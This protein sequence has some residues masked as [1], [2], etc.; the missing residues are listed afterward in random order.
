[1][2]VKIIFFFRNL[3]QEQLQVI[4]AAEKGH[5]VF[6]TGQA[7]TGKSYVVRELYRRLERQGKKV[8]IVCSSGIACLVYAA[9]N[10]QSE[11]TTVHSFF[12]LQTADLPSKLVVD[13]ATSNNLVNER[14]SEYDC[15]IW[16]EVSMS[17]KRIF[18]LVNEI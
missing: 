15:L 3:T 4:E 9:L 13:R 18:E 5:N 6:I 14:I 1:M 2:S 17:S 8:R 7:G 10:T 12:G 16:D 11:V